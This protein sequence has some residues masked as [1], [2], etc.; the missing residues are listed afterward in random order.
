MTIWTEQKKTPFD[1]TALILINAT[2]M[3]ISENCIEK[4]TYLL[5]LVMLKKPQQ[6]PPHPNPPSSS[7]P[8]PKKPPKTPARS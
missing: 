3:G 7:P 1:L 6:T 8:K 5:I 4:N 2:V